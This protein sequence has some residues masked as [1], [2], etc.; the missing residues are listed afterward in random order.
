M[1]KMAKQEP[2][3]LSFYGSKMILG[4][5]NNFGR[6]PIILDGSNSFC[7]GPNHFGQVH[8]VTISPEKSNL[9]LN[10][11]IWTFQNLSSIE[12]QGIEI[13]HF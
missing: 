3:P 11:M 1:T 7:S 2:N 5:Q 6:V 12:R 4:S 9:N 10:K 8:I 13:G